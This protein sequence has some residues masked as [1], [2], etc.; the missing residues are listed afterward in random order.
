MTWKHSGKLI[1]SSDKV[2]AKSTHGGL[3]LFKSG[4]TKSKLQTDIM[5]YSIDKTTRKKYLFSK[6]NYKWAL[7]EYATN[8]KTADYS[9]H[10]A[11]VLLHI[12]LKSKIWT[13]NPG[14]YCVVSVLFS[15]NSITFIPFRFLI[16]QTIVVLQ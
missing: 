6:L 14:V 4:C 11:D 1:L 10:V 3:W 15:I 2:M 16:I 13:A 12:T 7:Y 5:L 8:R 9:L